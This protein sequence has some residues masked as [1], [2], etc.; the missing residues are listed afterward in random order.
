MELWR[1]CFGRMTSRIPSQKHSRHTRQLPL[2]QT[3]FTQ[4][5]LGVSWYWWKSDT[6]MI[7][8]SRARSKRSRRRILCP[9]HHKTIGYHFPKIIHFIKSMMMVRNTIKKFWD[10][11]FQQ[12][13][14]VLSYP[15]RSEIWQIIFVLQHPASRSSMSFCHQRHQ[16]IWRGGQCH[17]NKTTRNVQTKCTSYKHLERGIVVVL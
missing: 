10:H 5:R 6:W 3:A 8:W 15:F 16:S 12:S 2:S 17:A 14:T 1:W 11:R 4:R 7:L 13:T 9:I